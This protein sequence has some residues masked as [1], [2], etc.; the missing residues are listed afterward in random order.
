[1]ADI[2]LAIV[3]AAAENGVIGRDN[4]LIWRLKSDLRRFRALTMGKPLI[5]GRKTWESIGR[6]LPGREIIVVTRDPAYAA[7]GVKVAHT[8]DEAVALGRGIA[9]ASG[10]DSVAVG[11]GGEVFR[12]LMPLAERIHLTIVH[13][14]PEGDVTFDPVDASV[15]REVAREAH[16]AGPDDEHAF[17]FV[18]YIRR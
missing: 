14:R 5:L 11:G 17:T 13:D 8:L 4:G 3:V 2:P 12:A 15:F 18:D 7:P 16:P 10:A 6:P 1:M 9:A